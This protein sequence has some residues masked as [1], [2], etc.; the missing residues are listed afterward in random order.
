VRSRTERK[1]AALRSQPARQEGVLIVWDNFE[2]AA[3][4]PGTEYA[5]ALPA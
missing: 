4:M 5:A 2:V 3:G 1:S